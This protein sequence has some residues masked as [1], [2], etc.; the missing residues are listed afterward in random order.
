MLKPIAKDV[1]ELMEYMTQKSCEELKKL[2]LEN[3]SAPL[4]IFVGE[5][6]WSSNYGYESVEGGCAD[7]KEITIYNG[8]WLDK[9]DYEDELC[10]DM[11]DDNR[12][13]NLPD[14]AY[15]KA[16]KEIVEQTAFVKAIVIYVG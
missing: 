4:L 9:L 16:V 2:I 15:D 1:K 14:D 12:Y 7:L 6:A 3:P 11:S 10:D 5:E 8:M 13:E